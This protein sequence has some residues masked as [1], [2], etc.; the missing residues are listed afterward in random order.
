MSDAAMTGPQDGGNTAIAGIDLGSNSFHLVVARADGEDIHVVD[1][2]KETVRL[3]AG[4]DRKRNLADEA[5]QRGL[6]CLAL[7]AQRVREIPPG[8]LRAVGTNA[9]RQARNSDEFVREGSNI[10]GHPIDV[11]SGR[12]EARFIYAGVA[13]TIESDDR[14]R[15]VMDIGGGS[16]EFIVGQGRYPL[17]LESLYMGC[18]S[19]TA[20]F[21]PDGNISRKLFD[22]AVVA[23]RQE[24]E[25]IESEYRG[26]GW[27]VSIGSSGTNLAIADVISQHMNLSCIDK[28][29]LSELRDQF[30]QLGKIELLT[31]LGFPADRA[32]VLPGGLA[33]LQA[34]FESLDIDKMS[35]SHG[36]LREGLLYDIVERMNRRDIRDDAVGELIE[37]YDVDRDQLKRVEQ[38]ALQCFEM[39]REKWQLDDDARK[40]LAWAVRLHEI[41]HTVS[42]NQY[43]KHG[44]YLARNHDL[45]GFS[46]EQQLLLATLVRGHRRKFPMSVIKELPEDQ[47]SIVSRL[48]VLLRLAVLLHRSRTPNPLGKF[49]LS[50]KDSRLKLVFA[51]DWLDNHPLTRADLSQE[52]GY[53]AKAEIELRI[54]WGNSD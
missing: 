24:L 51:K 31:D 34:A 53:L 8:R 36:A 15:L 20:R 40:L 39:V 54:N 50:A 12:E 10:L 23:A 28:S 21:F 29:A 42:H 35:V 18:V 38:T 14:R 48:C 47:R 17:L 19:W 49:K 52:A 43:H 2:I 16:T 13:R 30:L 45:R 5:I 22:A 3:G 1:R 4:L 44:E 26:M 11:I 41:G 25:S 7:F 33:I 27:E 46:R 32:Q 6:D 37:R 9:L